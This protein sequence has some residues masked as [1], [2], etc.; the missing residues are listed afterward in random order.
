MLEQIHVESRNEK[1][2]KN[3]LRFFFLH[4]TANEGVNFYRKELWRELRSLRGALKGF[5]LDVGYKIL[6]YFRWRNYHAFNSIE[7]L[8]SFE[9]RLT[10]ISKVMKLLINILEHFISVLLNEA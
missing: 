7:H 10:R 2:V 5:E 1:M 9:E 8:K 3:L 4:E 6:R